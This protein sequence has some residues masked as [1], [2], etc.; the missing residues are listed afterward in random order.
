MNFKRRQI[1][2]FLKGKILFSSLK[3]LVVQ[4]NGNY[5]HEESSILWAKANISIPEVIEMSK[6][7]I[8]SIDRRS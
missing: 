8:Y 1:Y 2:G 3:P 5:N 7:L 4:K 6:K